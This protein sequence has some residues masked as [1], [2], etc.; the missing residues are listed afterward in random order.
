MRDKYGRGERYEGGSPRPP[1][2]ARA[3]P[4]LYFY[5]RLITGPVQWLFRK[6]AAGQCDD[7]AWVAASAACADE[8]ERIGGSLIV[9]G[10]DKV[11]A[12]EGPCVF[13]ANHMSVME[14]FFLPA[15][16][17]PIKPVTF[18]VKKSLTTMPLFGPV[19]RSRDPVVVRRENPRE[20]L[21]TVLSG[22]TERLN[23]GV[24]IV[25]V[26]QHTRSREF[27]PR[28]FNTIGEKLAARAGVPLIPLALKTDAWGMGRLAKELGRIRPDIPARFAFGEP[29]KIEG[30]GREQRAAIRDF[31]MNKLVQW[32]N[33][34]G[35]NK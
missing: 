27:D 29:V 30:A 1:V 32:Q 4:S 14:T 12:T 16:I 22:G 24:S 18:V 31:I 33:E 7:A 2:M 23:K 17:R 28:Q 3:F 26:P 10:L 19:M 11:A 21:A 15:V 25:V 6:G 34:D 8:L 9:E 35:E 13:V 20:D 5:Y